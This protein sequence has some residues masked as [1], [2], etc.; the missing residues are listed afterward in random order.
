[1]ANLTKKPSEKLEIEESFGFARKR[2]G[3]Y[4][5]EPRNVY[6]QFRITASD[7]SIICQAAKTSGAE[8]PERWVRAVAVEQAKKV[9][10]P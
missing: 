2:G 3:N 8:S 4:V 5:S 9:T 1:M 7:Y 10:S 6:V